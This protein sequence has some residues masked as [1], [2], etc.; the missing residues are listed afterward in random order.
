MEKQNPEGTDP[1]ELLKAGGGDPHVVPTR[2]VKEF[3]VGTPMSHIKEEPSEDQEQLE[4]LQT[5]YS[6][7]C[8]LESVASEDTKENQ[9]SWMGTCDAGQEHQEEC[10]SPSLAH[11]GEGVPAATDCLD[12]PIQIKEE[13]LDMEDAIKLEDPHHHDKKFCNREAERIQEVFMELLWLVT[14]KSV[15]ER[16]NSIIYVSPDSSGQG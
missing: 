2:T 13:A 16:S 8:P 6:Q 4:T 14:A 9:T 5:S 12:S 15:H 11:L 1:R 10:K 3:L 7:T